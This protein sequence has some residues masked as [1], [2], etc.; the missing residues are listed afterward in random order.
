MNDL[1]QAM[2]FAVRKDDASDV[3][4]LY[5]PRWPGGPPICASANLPAFETQESAVAWQNAP[6]KT[7]PLYEAN[8]IKK[9]WQCEKCRHWH[10][11]TKPRPPSGASSGSGRES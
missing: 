7:N 10:F 2:D 3:A 1:D 4:K 11:I 5:P 8:P 9:I 6:N